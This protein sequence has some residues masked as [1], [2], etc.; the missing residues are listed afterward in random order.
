MRISPD[1]SVQRLDDDRVAILD[2]SA[3][4]EIVIS[5]EIAARLLPAMQYFFPALFIDIDPPKEFPA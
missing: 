3:H 5:E 4:Q 1:I 2:N